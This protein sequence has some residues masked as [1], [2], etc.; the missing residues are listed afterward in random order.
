MNNVDDP[1]YNIGAA[2]RLS[3][4]SREKIR[5]WERR[6]GAIEPDRDE[7][8]HRLYSRQDIERLILIRKL[9]DGGNAVSGVATL[10]RAELAARLAKLGPEDATASLRTALVISSDGEGACALLDD[11]GVTEVSQVGGVAAADLWLE[12]HPADLIVVERPTLLSGDY[13]DLLHLRRRAAGGQML[14]VYRFASR[15][16]LDQLRLLGVRA[17]KA[18]LTR[19]HLQLAASAT[20]ADGAPA[21]DHRTRRYSADQL[22]QVAGLAT[23]VQCECPRHLAD[24]VRELSAFEDYSLSCEVE[25]PDDAAL[26]REIYEVVA[27]ARSLV[28]DA[29]GIVAHEERLDL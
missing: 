27:R 9:V 13:S 29:L 22:R 4:V 15:P 10:S 5:I 28:E 1:R 20:S 14:L 24:L 6:Y 12:Q 11:L 7:T 3:G 26:H 16:I 2:S 25:S 21:A 19:D 23:E 17:V 8:N 18:P